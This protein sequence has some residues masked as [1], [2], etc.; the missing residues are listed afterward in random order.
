[1]RYIATVAAMVCTFVTTALAQKADANQGTPTKEDRHDPRSPGAHPREQILDLDLGFDG[2]TC[3]GRHLTP[4]SV[5]LA[6]TAATALTAPYGAPSRTC[7][8]Q[9]PRGY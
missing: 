7:R 2:L 3:G 5:R 8:N 6:E 1:M 4:I 9:Q